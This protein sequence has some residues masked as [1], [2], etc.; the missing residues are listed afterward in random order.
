MYLLNKNSLA[1]KITFTA[2]IATGMAVTVLL[3]AFLVLDS[4]SSRVLLNARLATLADVVGQNST[5]ALN[6][7][8]Q[9]AAEEILAAL[10]AESPIVI[11]CLWIHLAAYSRL[12]PAKLGH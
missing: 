1:H 11:A 4:V 2:L 6:F 9:A 5:A 12:T 7:N 3:S 10:K 8:D